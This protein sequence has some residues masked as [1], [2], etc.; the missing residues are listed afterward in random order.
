MT[1]ATDRSLAA[2]IADK[3][4]APSGRV[5]RKADKLDPKRV[6]VDPNYALSLVADIQEL[7]VSGHTGLRPSHALS[8]SKASQGSDIAT[9]SALASESSKS[10]AAS[11]ASKWQ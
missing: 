8:P 3:Y 4:I 1:L 5:R 9:T 6:M 10:A 11:L 7:I 2:K